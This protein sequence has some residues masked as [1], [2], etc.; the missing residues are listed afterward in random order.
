M[1]KER[2]KALAKISDLLDE[3]AE[4]LSGLKSSFDEV[5][6]DEVSTRENMPENLQDSERAQN[7][8]E[9]ISALEEAEA[10]FEEIESAI[11]TIKSQIDSAC[12]Y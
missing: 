1:N 11:E 5:K 6:E 12:N 3:V 4:T 2:R 8:D 7:M 9:A 10:A